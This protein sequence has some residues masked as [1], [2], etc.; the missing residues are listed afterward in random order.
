MNVRMKQASKTHTNTLFR[1]LPSVDEVVRLP[2]VAELATRE[3]VPPVLE[4]ARVVVAQMRSEIAA[5]RLDEAGIKLATAGIAEAVRR[6][7]QKTFTPS[8][9]TVINATGVVL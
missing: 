6:G 5:G 1:R 7:L 2:A 3:G 8:L 4:A 9:R